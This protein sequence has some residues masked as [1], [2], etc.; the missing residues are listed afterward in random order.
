[1]K[2]KVLKKKSIFSIPFS[3]FKLI[4]PLVKYLIWMRTELALFAFAFCFFLLNIPFSVL[5]LMV[6]ISPLCL[7][8]TDRVFFDDKI[9]ASS[10]ISAFKIFVSAAFLSAV[11]QLAVSYILIWAFFAALAWCFSAVIV[12]KSSAGPLSSYISNRVHARQSISN[13]TNIWSNL[14]IDPATI[15]LRYTKITN[16]GIR[17]TFKLTGKVSCATLIKNKN[18]IATQYANSSPGQNISTNN[19]RIYEGRSA[20]FAILEVRTVDPLAN[21]APEMNIDV[22]HRIDKPF[23][24]GIDENGNEVKFDVRQTHAGVYGVTGSGKSGALH[25]ITGIAAKDPNCVL[26]LADPK[27]GVEL[28][29]WKSQADYFAVEHKDIVDMLDK[30]ISNMEAVQAQMQ[31]AGVRDAWKTGGYKTHVII[32]DEVPQL[33]QDTAVDS[34]R[35][36]ARARLAKLTQ[37]GRA[38]KFVVIIAAQRPTADQIPK[39][40]ENNISSRIVLR[41]ESKDVE[42]AVLGK[43]F[44]LGPTDIP[45]GQQGRCYVDCAGHGLKETRL[46]HVPDKT[47]IKWQETSTPKTVEN[48]L[49]LEHKR[50]MPPIIK[51]L[52]DDS[53]AKDDRFYKIWQIILENP[54]TVNEII[55]IYNDG[56]DDESLHLSNVQVSRVLTKLVSQN[57]AGIT[58]ETESVKKNRKYISFS[59]VRG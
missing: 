3:I 26:Y 29:G 45:Q 42:R 31:A 36:A 19:I 18:L 1:M 6:S 12:S 2:I 16:T 20:N 59:E 23:P 4:K 34:I 32:L 58:K 41:L 57:I 48:E 11:G 56:V 27:G 55:S 43:H 17:Y 8:S 51:A 54:K 39:N 25:L 33:I 15:K 40:I 30:A 22:I 46:Y 52:E 50:Q 47:L 21:I 5:A 44:D 24:I 49:D 38:T 7:Y 53:T 9:S 35:E 13:W 14:S 10:L 28:G 37:L